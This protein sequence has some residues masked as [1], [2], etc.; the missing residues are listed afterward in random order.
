MIKL[1]FKIF[2]SLLYIYHFC[3]Y[4]NIGV[5]ILFSLTLLLWL[6]AFLY[7]VKKNTQGRWQQI[8]FTTVTH[9]GEAC[10]SVLPRVSLLLMACEFRCSLLDLFNFSL[11]FA[12][13]LRLPNLSCNISQRERRKHKIPMYFSKSFSWLTNVGR[14]PKPD[15]PCVISIKR[16]ISFGQ[17]L[18]QT[19]GAVFCVHHLLG[20]WFKCQILVWIRQVCRELPSQ[21]Q[22]S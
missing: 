8:S 11:P 10:K 7:V 17:Y 19:Q 3:F 18:C 21:Q 4:L 16:S 13:L 1:I 6:L 5:L 22:H 2:F 12:N 20:V 15:H 14:G 9:R